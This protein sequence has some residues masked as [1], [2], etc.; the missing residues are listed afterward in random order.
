MLVRTILHQNTL[1]CKFSQ[2]TICKEHARIDSSLF[3]LSQWLSFLFPQTI[4]LCCALFSSWQYIDRLQYTVYQY[5]SI[6]KRAQETNWAQIE[7]LLLLSIGGQKTLQKN[8]RTPLPKPDMKN[9]CNLRYIPVTKP[10]PNPRNFWPHRLKFTTTPKND[11][12]NVR[13]NNTSVEI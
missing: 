3:S 6:A 4:Y 5:I 8:Q 1:D 7:D 11:R 10:L 2:C 13:T 12:M 9:F